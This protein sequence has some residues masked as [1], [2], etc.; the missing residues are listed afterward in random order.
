MLE[1][2][3]NNYLSNPE[4]ALEISFNELSLRDSPPNNSSVKTYVSNSLRDTIVQITISA[5]SKKWNVLDSSVK[6]LIF[7]IPDVRIRLDTVTWFVKRLCYADL[8]SEVDDL[9]QV[10]KDQFLLSHIR[11]ILQ[12]HEGAHS[13]NDCFKVFARAIVSDE[14]RGS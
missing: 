6:T 8:H 1:Y 9:L 14:E 3:Q 4:F 12:N 2:F 5:L 10:T 13:L 11:A 7:G